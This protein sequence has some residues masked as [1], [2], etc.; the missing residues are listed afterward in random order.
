MRAEIDFPTKYDESM[1]TVITQELARFNTLI[2]RIGATLKEV[3]KALKGLVVMSGELEA[4]GNSMVSGQVP[5]LWSNV[6]YPSLKPLGGWV[7]DFLKRLGFFQKWI[8]D[9][10]APIAFWINGFF[11]TQAFITGT[12][13]N[14]A[15]KYQVPIDLVS[16]DN[17]VLSEAESAA[18]KAK[19][20]DGAY[21]YG[22]FIEGCRWDESTKTLNESVPKVLTE[23]FP[24]IHLLPKETKKIEPVEDTDPNGTAHVYRC[25][26]YKTSLRQ[27]KLSTTGHSTN[28]VMFYK[29]PML[30][31]H[32]QR[33]WIRRGVAMLTQLDD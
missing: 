18:V 29:V 27:G 26:V 1:N 4:M 28:F 8:D 23:P 31:Q 15:R 17:T 19:P 3:Q 30:P 22:L 21:L 14:F 5:A 24:T 16:Y 32:R 13:Q 9:Q 20:E 6:S 10:Q 25:P 7:D 11:F 2:V 12:K 33:H